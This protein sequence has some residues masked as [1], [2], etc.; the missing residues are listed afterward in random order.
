M[1]E[2][3]DYSTQTI[4]LAPDYEGKVVATLISLNANIGNRKAV[5]YL[6]G[7][8][9]YFFQEHLGVAFNANDFDFYALDLRK[10]GRS[11]LAHQH[12]NYCRAISEYF[13]ELDI[14]IRQISKSSNGEIYLMGHSTGGLIACN[15]MNFGKEQGLIKGLLLNSPFLNYNLSKLEK[16]TIKFTAGPI[17]SIFPYAKVKGALSPAYVKSIHKDFY[18]I[19]DFNLDW[20]PLEGFATYFAWLA[21]IEKAQQKL[22]GSK[23][24]V[25]ILIL[26]SH[27][28][29]K[30]SDFQEE[31]MRKD[32]VL[33]V[34]DIK[35]IGTELGSK[36]SL[37]EIVDAKH[38]VFL[39][40][41]KVREIAFK[42]MFTWFESL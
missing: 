9:D 18:G 21:A 26:H 2:L 3:K 13:E 6:H 11:L 38:D 31:A 27:A 19:W 42:E 16:A 24:K 37:L 14:A 32:I 28:S 36:V 30:F 34:A 5:L 22:K 23:I 12:P 17:S 7:Y 29:S 25:P 33:D 4:P 10:Y 8:L 1:I 15:Y 35:R 41:T 40:N 39:S 20:K